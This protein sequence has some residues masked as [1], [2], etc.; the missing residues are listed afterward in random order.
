[1]KLNLDVMPH[2]SEFVSDISTPNL[3]MVAGV[4]SGKTIALQQKAIILSVI[5]PGCLGILASP[6]FAMLSRNM[7]N[8]RNGLPVQLEKAGIPFEFRG[9][10]SFYLKLP[11]GKVSEIECTHAGSSTSGRTAA[12]FGVDEIDLMKTEDALDIWDILSAR[13][14]DPNGKHFQ[15]FC[16]STPEGPKFLWTKF[17]DDVAK[18]P[19]LEATFKLLHATTYDNFLLPP[20]FIERLEKQYDSKRARAHLMGEFVSLT[21]GQVYED[22][23]RK[24]NHTDLEIEVGEDLHIGVDFNKNGMSAP[25]FVIRDG[26][27]LLLDEIMG[28]TN[29]PTLVQAI[30]A[31][32]PTN[33]IT[34]YP[35]ATGKDV[36]STTSSETDHNILRVDGG[37][38]ISTTQANPKILDRV[39]SVRAQI[40]N[41]RGERSLK[42]NTRKCPISTGCFEQ[43]TL[44]P[45]GLPTKGIKYGRMTL[46]IDGPMDAAGYFIDRRFPAPRHPA[47]QP[48]RILG[49]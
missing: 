44:R 19:S 8:M 4:G 41:S 10:N 40:C 38:I 20:G 34:A 13:L 6:T 2:V 43:H 45:D 37:F 22:F 1:V 3:G 11:G 35:D 15:G 36:R 32:Y 42:V 29:T 48:V 47:V 31:R 30:R 26:K 5:N 7:L 9:G 39:N 24:L 16:A 46:H 23:D 14:R 49:A 28:S 12:W 17:V 18:D 33:R 25:I 21:Q 27:P